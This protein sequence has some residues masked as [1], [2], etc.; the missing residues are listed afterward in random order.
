MRNHAMSAELAI[1]LSDQAFSSLAAAAIA[2]GKTPA[3][4]AA[5]VVE[6]IFTATAGWL[7]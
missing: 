6:T 4:Q 5:A 3:E 1:Q 7:D 2:A